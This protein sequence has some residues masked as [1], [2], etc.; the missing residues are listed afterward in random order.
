MGAFLIS[1]LP[2]F[3]NQTFC[4]A[5][6]LRSAGVAPLLRY[7]RPSRRR[8]AFDRFPGGTGDTIYL[9][10]PISWWDEDGFSSCSAC[11]CH[12]AVPYHPAEGTGRFSLPAPCPV[13]FARP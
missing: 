13:A 12:R 1:P 4:A 10:P 11:P 8:L 3:L 2:P 9:A 5:R 7:Y 6:P